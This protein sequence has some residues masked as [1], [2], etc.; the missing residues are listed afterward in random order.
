MSATHLD[1]CF[2]EVGFHGDLFPRVNVGIV[3][4]LESPFKFSQLCRGKRRPN[5][6]LFPLFAENALVVR[7]WGRIDFVRESGGCGCG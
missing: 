4:L 5:P 6:S 7:R 1:S 3:R 2:C